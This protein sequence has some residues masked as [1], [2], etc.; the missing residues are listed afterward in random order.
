M[1]EQTFRDLLLRSNQHVSLI[2]IQD[3]KLSNYVIKG[4]NFMFGIRNEQNSE[5]TE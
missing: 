5:Y 3:V 4:L 1:S 2:E